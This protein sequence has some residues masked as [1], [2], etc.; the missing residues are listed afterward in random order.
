MIRAGS[1]RQVINNEL[2]SEIQGVHNNN[3]VQY[4]RDDLEANAL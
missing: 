3:T 4:I 1:A 2:G